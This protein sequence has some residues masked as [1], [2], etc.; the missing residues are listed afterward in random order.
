MNKYY[1]T[2]E[3]FTIIKKVVFFTDE[4]HSK[5]VKLDFYIYLA[6]I[7]STNQKKKKKKKKNSI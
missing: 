2:Y 6:Q 1:W 4:F 7:I 5:K 3:L